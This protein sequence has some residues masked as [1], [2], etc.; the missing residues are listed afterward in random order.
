[1]ISED[2]DLYRAHPDWALGVPGRPHTRGRSQLTLDFSRQ[3]VR[4]HIYT[5]IKKVPLVSVSRTPNQPSSMTN[6]SSPSGAAD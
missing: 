4:D 3:E 1:M 6:S 2:S 5:A